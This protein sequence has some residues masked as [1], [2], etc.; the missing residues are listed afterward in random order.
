M[1][2]IEYENDISGAIESMRGSDNRANVSARSDNRAYYNSRDVQQCYTMTYEHTAAADGQYSF[3]LKNTSPDKTL[4]L[5]S[6]GL[7]CDTAD[8]RFK[9]WFVSGTATDGVTKTPTNLNSASSNAAAVTALHDGGGTTIGGLTADKEIDYI[10][11]AVNT[12]VELR[13]FDRVRLGQ[14]DAVA[15][16][17]DENSGGTADAGGVVF[18]YFE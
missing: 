11:V 9:L 5:S 2:K 15:L 16:E 18:F 4:V 13:L 8:S 17:F 12:H 1:S 6:V 10:F 14:N 3:Y 7:N